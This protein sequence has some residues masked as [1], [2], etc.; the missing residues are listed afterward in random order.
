[1]RFVSVFSQLLQL[2]PRI[3]FQRA[4]TDHR[5]KGHAIGR[6]LLRA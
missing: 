2:F 5:A 6:D 4:V 3:E 1:M